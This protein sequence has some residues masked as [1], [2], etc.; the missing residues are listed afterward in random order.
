[1]VHFDI[2]PHITEVRIGTNTTDQM[3]LCCVAW[4]IENIL[5]LG[6]WNVF[7]VSMGYPFVGSWLHFN[8]CGSSFI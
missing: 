2:F 8:F 4:K 6:W 3:F 5:L 1:M 7:V